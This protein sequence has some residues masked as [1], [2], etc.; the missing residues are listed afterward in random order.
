MKRDRVHLL[1]NLD[2]VDLKLLVLLIHNSNL[3]PSPTPVPQDL[4]SKTIMDSNPN[5]NPKEI[6]QIDFSSSSK[7]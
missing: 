6:I 2:L 4:L 7:P 3:L 5:N 1:D